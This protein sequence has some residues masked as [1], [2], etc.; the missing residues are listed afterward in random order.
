MFDFLNQHSTITTIFT[1]KYSELMILYII[2]ATIPSKSY[3]GI[4]HYFL[5][6]RD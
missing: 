1:D 4:E 6:N 3:K 2:L 5:Q